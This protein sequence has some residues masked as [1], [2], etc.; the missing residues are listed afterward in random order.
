MRPAPVPA[1]Q[2]AACWVRKWG[3]LRLVAINSSKLSSVASRRSRRSR[4]A[5][6]A[7]F[8]SKSRV[9]KRERAKASSPAILGA[10][11]LALE[12]LATRLVAQGIRRVLASAVSGDYAMS[13]GKL[14]GDGAA[15]STAAAGNNRCRLIHSK[16]SGVVEYE[17]KARFGRNAYALAP[18]DDLRACACRCT[19]TGADGRALA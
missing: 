8:T 9:S 12:D 6:P 17:G 5:M 11:D 19:S 15:D 18:D 2:R 1:I 4:G 16:V 10:R 7:L 14:R 13:P 3:P